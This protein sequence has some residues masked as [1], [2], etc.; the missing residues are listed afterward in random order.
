MPTAASLTTLSPLIE[1]ALHRELARRR[2]L[3]AHAQLAIAPNATATVIETAFAQLK[4]QYEPDAFAG[5][6]ETAITAA[7]EICALLAAARDQM[8][9]RLTPPPAA[10]TVAGKRSSRTRAWLRALR[11]SLWLRSAADRGDR[12]VLN[13]V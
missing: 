8:R 10:P 5:Y 3:R 2:G 1:R 4:S 7:S 13:D 12:A 11:R 6:G 9:A